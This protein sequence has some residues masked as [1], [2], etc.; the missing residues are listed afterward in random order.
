MAKIT[1]TQVL[2][3]I[4]A[5]LI[6]LWLINW[7]VSCQRNKNTIISELA[8]K[9]Q[10]NK[11]NHQNDSF[12]PNGQFSTKEQFATDNQQTYNGQSLQTPYTQVKTPFILYYFYNP[13]CIHCK[14]FNPVW[15]AI[16]SKL[17]PNIITVRAIDGTKPENDDLTFYYN[18]TGYPTVVLVT[19]IDNIEYD[20]D[21]SSD[22]LYNFIVTKIGEYSPDN[23]FT[24]S[25]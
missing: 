5:I 18:L 19:P 4:L 17:N 21:R 22:D 24:T 13:G 10:L 15:N 14:Q 16:T 23:Q 7:Y 20:G 6:L 8:G 12:N 1:V 3:I 11:L 9:G 2:L 25:G